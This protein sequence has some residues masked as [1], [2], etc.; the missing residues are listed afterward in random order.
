MH[1][2]AICAI[3]ALVL[4]AWIAFVT[5]VAKGNEKNKAFNIYSIDVIVKHSC[6]F[7]GHHYKST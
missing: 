2:G 5:A 6:A 4:F 1:R 7:A 3:F